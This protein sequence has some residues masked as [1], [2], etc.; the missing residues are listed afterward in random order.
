MMTRLGDIT[1]II[2]LP[3]YFTF[4]GLRTDLA[5]LNDGY[6][7]G[8][9]ILILTVAFFSKVLGSATPAYLFGKLSKK[10]ALCFGILLQTKGLMALIV[11]NV[12]LDY[13]VITPKFFAVNV[14]VVVVR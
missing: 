5:A 3:L 8:V 4:S 11:F 13:G 10:E 6:S 9:L 1:V 14:V 12:G 7:W 2:L